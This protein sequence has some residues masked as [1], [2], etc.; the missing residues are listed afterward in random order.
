MKRPL[1]ASAVFF[2]AG[3]Y[4]GFYLTE[5]AAGAAFFFA[6]AL[7]AAAV[8]RE[9][10]KG[11]LFL[12]FFIAALL[13]FARAGASGRDAELDGIAES[14]R[15]VTMYGYIGD[16][17]RTVT[18]RVKAAVS[19]V[20]VIDGGRTYAKKFK[21]QAIFGEGVSVTPGSAVELSGRLMVPERARN[22]GGFDEFIYLSARKLE[23]KSFAVLIAEQRRPG[24]YALTGAA[25]ERLA[26]VYDAVL[27]EREAGIIKSII[28]GDRSGLDDYT[29]ELFKLAGIYHILAISGLHISAFA[30]T[31]NFLLR[32][33]LPRRTSGAVCMALLA[34]YCVMTGASPSTVRAVIMCGCIVAGGML[35]R[36]ADTLTSASFACCVILLY[37][38]YFIFDAGFR[39]SFAAVASLCLL[40]GPL[41]RAVQ[42]FIKHGELSDAVCGSAAV[43]IGTQPVALGLSYYFLPYSV[44]VN[45]LILPTVVFLLAAGFA[46]GVAGLFSIRAASFFA[47]SVYFTLRIYSA[48]CELFIKLPGAAVLVGRMAGPAAFLYY[49]AVLLFMKTYSSFEAEFVKYKKIFAVCAAAFAVAFAAGRFYPYAFTATV[50]DVGQ[51][52]AAVLNKNGRAFIVD[53]GGKP[54]AD[55]LIPYLN[56]SGIKKADAAFVSHFDADHLTG[57]IGLVDKHRVKEVFYPPQGHSDPSYA[58]FASLCESRG[59]PLTPIYAGDVVASRGGRGY[60]VLCLHPAY[61]YGP[62]DMNDASLVLKAVC[63]G[64]SFLFTGDVGTA[65]EYA[66]VNGG[67]DIAADILKLA[68][69]GSRFSTSELFLEYAKPLAAVC[70]AG[71]NNPYGHPSADT[72]ARLEKYGVSFYNTA[73]YGAVVVSAAGGGYR[74]R[75]QLK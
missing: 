49:A 53:G 18:D 9:R 52:D 11:R 3:T 39:Y 13:G 65:A 34:L 60:E 1:A 69:H 2:I 29:G 41:K 17:S 8:V 48:V 27:P 5:T 12:I 63:D 26:A 55:V 72:L 75:T 45:I 23:Y 31:V 19:V 57:L 54:G 22:P 42:K 36:P 16:V 73:D 67:V 4:A 38:P 50:L 66:L 28:I 32:R 15:A 47:G 56:Y 74:I 24:L 10:Y 68:H 59:I 64:A 14:G 21:L 33:V 20:E 61:G 40:T 35:M 30:L 37:E 62:Y 51:G 46:T 44:A 70:G 71:R 6:S 43:F 58:G 7:F 25:G